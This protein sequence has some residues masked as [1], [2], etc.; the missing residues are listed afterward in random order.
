MH[1]AH[2]KLQIFALSSISSLCNASL[3]Q[4]QPD[5][6]SQQPMGCC[7]TAAAQQRRAVEASRLS[8]PNGTE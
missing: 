5:V 2:H 1:A 3:Q 8:A 6:S 4:P 7:R